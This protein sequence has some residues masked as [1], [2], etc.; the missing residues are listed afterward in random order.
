[1]YNKIPQVSNI[2]YPFYKKGR[3]EGLLGNQKLHQF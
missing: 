3:H 2:P 1:M